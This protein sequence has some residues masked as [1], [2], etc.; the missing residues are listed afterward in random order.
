MKDLGPLFAVSVDL[1]DAPLPASHESQAHPHLPAV[2]PGTEWKR[3]ALQTPGEEARD[4]IGSVQKA[5]L[6]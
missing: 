3:T 6:P 4:Q 2:L 5:A 1:D